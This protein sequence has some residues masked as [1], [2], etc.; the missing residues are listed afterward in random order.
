[1]TRNAYSGMT[2]KTFRAHIV[3]LMETNRAGINVA[4]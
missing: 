3:E 4:P 1:M 2:V